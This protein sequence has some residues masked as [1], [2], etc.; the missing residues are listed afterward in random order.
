MV[1]GM[2]AVN[3]WLTSSD[4][5]AFQLTRYAV[6]AGRASIAHFSGPSVKDWSSLICCHD[7]IQAK[8]PD[9]C[10][11]IIDDS[12]KTKT[13]F[14]ARSFHPMPSAMWFITWFFDRQLLGLVSLSVLCVPC[15]LRVRQFLLLSLLTP[16][17]KNIACRLAAKFSTLVKVLFSACARCR[18]KM[19]VCSGPKKKIRT[20]S[21]YKT[22]VFMRQVNLHTLLP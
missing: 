1:D 19:T 5:Y 12:T 7:D 15:A 11:R 22:G 4:Y 16:H 20:T 6:R 8:V 18:N 10:W 14:L 13:T 17:E 9:K 21:C 3:L 2:I